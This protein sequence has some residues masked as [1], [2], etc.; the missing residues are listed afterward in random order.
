MATVNTGWPRRILSIGTGPG[1]VIGDSSLEVVL[2]RLRPDGVQ[3]LDSMTIEDYRN[4]PAAEW[5]AEYATF[6]AKHASK[7][8]AAVAVLPRPQ[9]VVRTLTLPG[10]SGQDAEAAIRFQLDTLHP[11]GDEE[12]SY[13]WKRLGSSTHYVVAIAERKVIDAYTALFYEA[14]VKLAGYTFSGG[15][16]FAA[17]RLYASPPADG[18][19]AFIGDSSEAGAPV[20]VYGES[21]TRPLLSAVFEEERDRV[22]TLMAAELRLGPEAGAVVLQDLLPAPKKAPEGFEVAR[23]PLAYAAALD[24]A[25]PHLAPLPN[26]LPMESRTSSSRAVYIPTAVLAFFLTLTA[27]GLFA[28]NRYLESGYLNRLEQET[29]KLEPVARKVERMDKSMA[30]M[31][32]RIRLLDD[33][34]L[35]TKLDLDALLEINKLMPPPSWAQQ[36]GL[37]RSE[38]VIGGE[39]E[40]AEDLLKRFDASPMF[41][42]SQ[43]TTPITRGVSGEMFRMR[44]QREVG[45]K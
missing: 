9:V 40:R 1:I 12:V 22:E 33:Y 7:H 30:E 42:D 31:S 4:R 11:F 36:I 41:R 34:R 44:T 38:V 32:E 23:Q 13:D 35:Q 2:A 21:A 3:V 25:C 14:G 37:N 29:R 19:I 16:V 26:L 27:V 8:K 45:T 6:L 15:A 20:E 17:L 43:F 5:G 39:S 28:Q 24:A 10:V 18:F